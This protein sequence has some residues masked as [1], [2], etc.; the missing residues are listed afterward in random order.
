MNW[1]IIELIYFI[2]ILIHILALPCEIFMFI[3]NNIPDFI[4][5]H[6]FIYSLVYS[7]VF[8]INLCIT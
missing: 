5:I 3:F 8:L 2:L 6:I 4:K 7:I 1:I